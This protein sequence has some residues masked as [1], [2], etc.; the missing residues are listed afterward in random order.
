MS[1]ETTTQ[2]TEEPTGINLPCILCGEP[3]AAVRLY[4]NDGSMQCCE[5]DGEFTL[6]DVREVWKRWSEVITWLDSRPRSKKE[7]SE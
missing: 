6:A 7:A 4:L 2:S 1:E 3:D 5:C